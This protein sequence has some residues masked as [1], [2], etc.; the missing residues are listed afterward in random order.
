MATAFLKRRLRHYRDLRPRDRLQQYSTE[1]LAKSVGINE[2]PPIRGEDPAAV[3]YATR[4]RKDLGDHMAFQPH[5]YM[6]NHPEMRDETRAI[7][8]VDRPG[9]WLD[10][11]QH[12]TNPT[13]YSHPA[14]DSYFVTHPDAVNY[15][16]PLAGRDIY[17]TLAYQLRDG[18]ETVED[19]GMDPYW[20]AMA[21]AYLRQHRFP[22]DYLL[23]TRISPKEGHARPDSS[24][25][26][27]HRMPEVAD[28]PRE[29]AEGFERANPYRAEI[30][31][32]AHEQG[33]SSDN[34]MH[35]YE[36][37]ADELRNLKRDIKSYRDTGRTMNRH[38][39]PAVI[40]HG[41]PDPTHFSSFE[42]QPEGLLSGIKE[43]GVFL[44][45][46]YDNARA[47][48]SNVD[49]SLK[50]G[51]RGRVLGVRYT[52][53]NYEVPVFRPF[54]FTDTSRIAQ[55]SGADFALYDP[56]NAHAPYYF[57]TQPDR[58]LRITGQ[59]VFRGGKDWQTAYRQTIAPRAER[60]RKG[61]RFSKDSLYDIDKEFG[62]NPGYTQQVLKSVERN[63]RQRQRAFGK[64]R[65]RAL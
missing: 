58:D 25:L 30:E 16:R 4:I 20:R 41:T 26:L 24:H 22:T 40:Y 62:L 13:R 6:E 12:L 51:R 36:R 31:K 21:N 32:L 48:A 9:M 56:L 57:S 17:N 35:R 39:A 15:D 65:S 14:E 10:A 3:R 64:T 52:P 53:T 45:E 59:D 2:L 54:S 63:E 23:S 37:S 47:Y 50:R 60:T 38:Y 7:L 55:D 61:S 34:L 28:L 42:P 18:R 8:S 11:A 1:G 5:L 43:G 33:G 29:F 19:V 49:T 46:D 27:L 44:T